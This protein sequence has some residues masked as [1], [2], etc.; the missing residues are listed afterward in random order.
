MRKLY[1]L[2]K[3]M[4]DGFAVM[5]EDYDTELWDSPRKKARIRRRWRRERRVYGRKEK[6][7][8]ADA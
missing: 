5:A 2:I 6:A 1:N 4:I 8:K 3:Y 7:K